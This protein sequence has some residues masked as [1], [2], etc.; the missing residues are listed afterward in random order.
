MNTGRTPALP[1]SRTGRLRRVRGVVL[2]GLLGL[3]A[4]GC[5]DLALFDIDMLLGRI[6]FISTL[7]WSVAPSPYEMPRLP[8]EGT[9]PAVNPR[10]DVPPPFTQQDLVQGAAAVE[11]LQN[12][13]QPTAAVLARGAQLYQQHC[14]ACHGADGGG[15]GPVVGPGKFPF[16][17]AA[18]AAAVAR[19]SDGYLYGIIRVGRGLMPAYG[20]RAGHLD[21][22]A[23]VSYMRQLGTQTGVTVPVD[24]PIAPADG[25][26]PA[27]GL[28]PGAAPGPGGGTTN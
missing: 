15:N 23:M 6:P 17:P 3:G 14:Y 11:G 9:V 24:A 20:D 16:A 7:R 8:A 26:S 19:Y 1:P 2:V 18:N 28:P 27:P 21:R 13:L 4:S 5:T 22:W 25:A 12:P 10:G